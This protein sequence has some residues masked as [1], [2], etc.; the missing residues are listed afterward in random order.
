MADDEVELLSI[1]EFAART[2]L[3]AKALRIYDRS[4]LLRPHHIDDLSGYR[5]YSP[6][7]VPIG[8][9]VRLLRAADL[10]LAAIDSV[11]A[12]LPASVENACVRLETLL[13]E[14]ERDH[15]GRRLV[16]RHVQSILRKDADPMFEIKTREVPARRLMSIQRRQRGDR[17][18]S[19]VAEARAA[20]TAHLGDAEPTGPFTLIF[21][22][23]VNDQSDGPIEA[24]LAA[25]PHIQPT[26][27]IGIRTEPAHTEAYTTITK[28]Q[29]DYP[30]ILAAYDAVA[31]CPQAAT[32]PGSSLSCR[33]V[34]LA[35][36]DSVDEDEP[37]CDIAYP[38]GD[39]LFVE[40]PDRIERTDVE[41]MQQSTAD[42]LAAIQLLWRQFERQVGLRGRKMYATAH[43][44][45]YTTCTPIRDNDDPDA[46]G[47]ERGI[48]RGG[49]YL[50]GQLRGEPPEL[51]T[52]IGPGVDELH[53]L[54]GASV[55]PERPI[56]EFYRR[57]NQIELWV[58]VLADCD[59]HD[60]Q[61]CSPL[62]GTHA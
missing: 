32:R 46:Y 38:L 3:S 22:G 54:A 50:R 42:D 47:L 33:E 21:H 26:E 53:R 25:P 10:S 4:G 16:V 36:P 62:P 37:I 18:D 59:E 12:E 57:H 19:F 56:V 44:G 49:S 15:H 48:L 40:L 58:P 9:L 23:P 41:V 39:S 28:R 2:R 45:T 11:I 31:S 1:G 5:R 6:Q 35:E 52:R 17:T 13:D 61:R 51:Y 30:A 60:T 27:L 20:F 7:Q 14:I 55:D 43:S 29:W 34:Y 24:A 8:R